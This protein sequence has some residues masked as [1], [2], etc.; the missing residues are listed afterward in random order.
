MLAILLSV[1]LALLASVAAV[2]PAHALVLCGNPSGSVFVRATC[3]SAEQQLDPVALGLQGPKGDKGDKGDPGT[4][5]NG[6]GGANG[7]GRQP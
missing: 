6:N 5:G 2:A 3:R 1:I 7:G 4:P